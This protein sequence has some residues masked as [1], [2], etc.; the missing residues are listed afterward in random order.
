MA[1]ES[2]SA[3]K[4]DA[5]KQVDDEQSKGYVGV[6]VDPRPNSAYSMESG[7]DSPPAVDDDVSRIDQPLAGKEG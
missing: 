3:A 7:P 1:K 5:Q 6:K 2:E 4:G